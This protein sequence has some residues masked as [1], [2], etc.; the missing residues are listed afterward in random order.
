MTP[1]VWA[2]SENVGVSN[3]VATAA[4]DVAKGSSAGAVV[5]EIG[6]AR[7]GVNAPGPVLLLKGPPQ[8]DAAPEVA[9]EALAR[10]A[11]QLQ[12]MAILI[13]ATRNGR[14]L[15]SRLASKLSVGCL[16]EV[17][18]L[19]SDGSSLSAERNAFAGKVLAK[20]SCAF[21][22]VATV[23]VGYYPGA[24]GAPGAAKEVDVGSIEPKVKVVSREKKA[25][26]EVDLK[27]AKVIV[28]AGRGVKKKEDLPMLEELA[29]DMHGALGCSRALSSDLGWLPEEHH[30][31]LTGV[32]VKPDL[33]LAVGISGQLQHTAGMKDSKVVAAINTD[34]DAPIFQASDYGIVG[35]LYQLVPALRK[36][37]ANRR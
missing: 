5:V 1:E 33:Y 4:A 8:S 22:A 30:I 34:K 15:A 31:G 28:S 14:E 12:P 19:S 36:A 29:K 6:A 2:Y 7:G 16:A 24:Q 32:T 18:R 26:G 23:K 20:V 10:A 9:A 13:G 17:S 25:V 3:E 27:R 11:K 35:D 37:L 21:P